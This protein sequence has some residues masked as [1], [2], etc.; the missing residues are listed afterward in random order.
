MCTLCNYVI[1]VGF[2]TLLT[3]HERQ[4]SSRGEGSLFFP[5]KEKGK[6]FF[7]QSVSLSLFLHLLPFP[8]E[9]KCGG[10]GAKKNPLVIP[11]FTFPPNISQSAEKNTCV[12]SATVVLDL[13]LHAPGILDRRES[14]S[15]CLFLHSSNC[16][17]C[18]R[19]K[20]DIRK[21]PHLHSKLFIISRILV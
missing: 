3:L 18:I 15:S 16:C 5:Q 9:K 1:S 10:G 12:S 21:V 13:L 20:S 4:L 2:P 14:I 19:G 7:R 11:H 8:S 6:N 17:P